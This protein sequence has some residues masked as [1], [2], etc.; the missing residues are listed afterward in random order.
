[1]YKSHFIVLF[2]FF[3]YVKPSERVGG[4]GN[5]LVFSFPNPFHPHSHLPLGMIRSRKRSNPCQ[6]EGSDENLHQ[7]KKKKQ[8]NYEKKHLDILMLFHCP[9]C[10][11]TQKCTLSS[12]RDTELWSELCHKDPR[13]RICNS[14]TFSS[15][16]NKTQINAFFRGLQS[17]HLTS[18]KCLTL[19]NMNIDKY[20][21]LLLT[22]LN[23]PKNK[24]LKHLT[25]DHCRLF[26]KPTCQALVECIQHAKHLDQLESVNIEGFNNKFKPAFL[27][28]ILESS[29][30]QH[31]HNLTRF[32]SQRRHV[33][34]LQNM[35]MYLSAVKLNSGLP[36][37]SVIDVMDHKTMRKAPKILQ[38]NLLQNARKVHI[39]RFLSGAISID[40]FISDLKTCDK[41]ILSDI[42]FKGTEMDCLR[43]V[44]V[45][46]QTKHLVTLKNLELF[47]PPRYDFIQTIARTLFLQS[48]HLAN[49]RRVV[50]CVDPFSVSFVH[51]LLQVIHL[52]PYLVSLHSLHLL[53]PSR[54]LSL[55]LIVQDFAFHLV[56]T[57]TEQLFQI[58]QT[59]PPKLFNLQ[60]I[61]EQ[62]AKHLFNRTCSFFSRM[63]EKRYG[64]YFNR[65]H[66]DHLGQ[67]KGFSYLD[68][69]W[70]Q[71]CQKR[72]FLFGC[73]DRISPR[74]PLFR[75]FRQQTLFDKNIIKIIW[76]FHFPNQ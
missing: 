29:S 6:N 23:H 28:P 15:L 60:L 67:I 2:V 12:F 19:Q 9:D 33:S 48:P 66:V 75:S 64:I 52:S 30:V 47:I 11:P 49:L 69:F 25:F 43:F 20:I 7:T 24:N 70:K 73:C 74:N 55:P 4:G 26:C 59:D 56:K 41:L 40:D 63:L 3:P 53:D 68:G 46:R 76:R 45:L 32:S 62:N 58:N 39:G 21:S 36:N 65:L 22:F 27:Q 72:I 17:K 54:K 16:S 5:P 14:I 57:K 13:W 10:E 37:L 8:Q 34:T 51:I 35:V 61:P 1:M 38:M 44:N 71:F 18:I 31:L 42:T 50:F